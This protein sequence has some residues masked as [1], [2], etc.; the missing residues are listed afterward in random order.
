MG[1]AG[2][3]ASEGRGGAEMS[4]EPVSARDATGMDYW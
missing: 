2:F 1:R 3:A 4:S